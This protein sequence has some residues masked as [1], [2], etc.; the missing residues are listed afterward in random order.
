MIKPTVFVHSNDREIIPA[1][2]AM[3]SLKRMSQNADK[4]NVK[5][6]NLED[7]PYLMNY[8][9]QS[10]LRNQIESAWYKDVPQSFFPLRFLV[11]QLMGYQG[12]AILIDPDIFA[13]SDIYELLSR[14]ME[15]KAIFSC[16]KISR[17]TSKPVKPSKRGFDTSVMLLDCSELGHWKWEET[18]NRLFAREIDLQHWIS[19]QT[20]SREI[21][22]TL[23]NEW[24]H[25]DKLNSETKLLHNTK[26]LTQPWKTGLAYQRENLGNY[27]K[28]WRDS[29]TNFLQYSLLGQKRPT[30]QQHPDIQQ[31]RLFFSLL[32]ECVEKGL[33]ATELIESKV[34]LG[35][36][37]PD[38]MD[39]I[40]SSKLSV[41]EILALVSESQSPLKTKL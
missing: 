18:I 25:R 19:L 3:Y 2:V 36:V 21:I 12:R 13:V 7:Y 22:G 41:D 20:E 4:F 1:T 5:L 17:P 39:S 31:E 9:G 23:E 40:A 26:Q 38:I 34:K 35:H 28:T 29:V 33:V 27:K 6:I 15:G 32:K 37:R 24:N 10:C 16:P 30:Y 14:D 11:P 8:D